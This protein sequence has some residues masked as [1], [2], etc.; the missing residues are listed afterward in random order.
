MGLRCQCWGIFKSLS[1]NIVSA[2]HLEDDREDTFKPEELI[3]SDSDPW[4][5]HL[6]TLWDVRFEQRK[7]TTED[8]VTQI[9]L[10]MRLTSNSFS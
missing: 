7:S 3:Q 1:V 8:K 9:N 5:K 6:N 10:K 2:I 4:F